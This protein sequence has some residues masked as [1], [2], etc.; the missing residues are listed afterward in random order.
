MVRWRSTAL[1]L[2]LVTHGCVSFVPASFGGIARTPGTTS[3]INRAYFSHGSGGICPSC[4][5]SSSQANLHRRASSAGPLMMAKG[6]KKG[7]GKAG[8]LELIESVAAATEKGDADSQSDEQDDEVATP[9]FN[10]DKLKAETKTPFRTF[11]IFIYGA[12]GV[13]ALIGGIT[14][15]TQLAATLSDQPGALEL[16]KVLINLL[17][18]FGVMAAAAFCYNFETSQQEDLEQVEAANRE[19]RQKLKATKITSDV[20][21]DRVK[22]LRALSVK[23]PG[24]GNGAELEGAK[25]APVG[26]LM[27][28]AKQAF[29]VLAG[30]KEFVRDSILAAMLAKNQIFPSLNLLVV[31]VEMEVASDGKGAK[32]LAKGFGTSLSYEEQGYV[33]A[34]VDEDGWR[35]LMREEFE[36]A[37][38]QGVVAQSSGKD[39]IVLLVS[40]KGKVLRRGVGIPMWNIIRDD[41]DPPPDKTKG[42][43]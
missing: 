26:V 18:D 38:R 7:K 2:G 11:R 16:Q 35:A 8:R 36:A 22:Q 19:K 32:G 40:K 3:S 5:V 20:N 41:V 12:F 14:S 28:E 10:I 6:R 15:L 31:P 37:E 33:A 4:H 23:V 13:S 9:A 39:G 21:A 24:S 29:C 25:E 27:D 34:P 30:G 1:I 17:V 43:K 42:A